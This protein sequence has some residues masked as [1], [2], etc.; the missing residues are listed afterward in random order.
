MV[1][2]VDLKDDLLDIVQD[3]ENSEIYLRH[4]RETGLKAIVAINSYK[5]GPTLGGCR[6]VPYDSTFTAIEDALLL[7]RAMTMKAAIA[8]VPFGG[9]KAVLINNE[10]IKDR[11]AYFTSYGKFIDS[12]D[13]KY[14]T[15]VD[16][17]TDIDD[18][19]IVATQ[20]KYVSSTSKMDSSPATYT[21]LGVFNGIKS[22]VK[23]KLKLD[24]LSGLHVTV[25]GVG[26]VGF[27]LCKMLA[28][29]GAKLT[30]T[31][32]NN[33]NL[34]FCKKNLDVNIVNPNEIFAIKSDIFSPNALGAILND[35]TI[36]QLKVSIIAGA[37]NNQLANENKHGNMIKDLGILY[38]PDYAINAGGLIYAANKYLD[39]ETPIIRQKVENI[40]NIL[41]NIFNIST[42]KNIHP[43]KI[44]HEMAADKLAKAKR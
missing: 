34:E 30:V 27:P 14:I 22:A 41:D 43:Q 10:E 12:L 17:G 28:S 11:K 38:A 26:A 6:C 9:G 5:L 4:D 35:E 24:S 36:S 16:S 21:A 33:N 31:D 18:M 19:D 20:T 3:N 32:V 42:T 44:A 2:I 7:A 25:Q 15:A 8:E 13:G 1:S 29:E 40:Y 39:V 37:A 23:H